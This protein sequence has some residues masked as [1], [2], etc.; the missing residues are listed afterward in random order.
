M[1]RLAKDQALRG[2]VTMAEHGMARV[3][4]QLATETGVYSGL[5]VLWGQRMPSWSSR[6][7]ELMFVGEA[8][9]RRNTCAWA[10]DMHQA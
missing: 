5:A 9:A 2:E 8:L 10:Q 3:G 6:E 4:P 7:A 1:R